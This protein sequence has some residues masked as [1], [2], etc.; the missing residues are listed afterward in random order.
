MKQKKERG[1]LFFT[2]SP[3]GMPFSWNFKDHLFVFKLSSEMKYLKLSESSKITSKEDLDKMKN[4]FYRNSSLKNEVLDLFTHSING[5]SHEIKSFN[6]SGADSDQ[7]DFLNFCLETR[8]NEKNILGEE[9]FQNIKNSEKTFEEVQTKFEKTKKNKIEPAL[10]TV[11]KKH[12][13]KEKEISGN[14]LFDFDKIEQVFGLDYPMKF[15]DQ[16]KKM[17]VSIVEENKELKRKDSLKEHTQSLWFIQIYDF[18]HYNDC[19][20]NFFYFSSLLKKS[21]SFSLKSSSNLDKIREMPFLNHKKLF[22]SFS[23]NLLHLLFTEFNYIDKCYFWTNDLVALIFVRNLLSPRVNDFCTLLHFYIFEIFINFIRLVDFFHVKENDYLEL[24]NIYHNSEDNKFYAKSHSEYYSK[25]FVKLNCK[26]FLLKSLKLAQ[27]ESFQEQR[28][29]LKNKQKIHKTMHKNG[30]SRRIY[31]MKEDISYSSILSEK[32]KK[33]LKEDLKKCEEILM[34]Q[35]DV[36]NLVIINFFCSFEPNIQKLFAHINSTP[37]PTTSQS[38]LHISNQKS[39][40]NFKKAETTEIFE[41]SSLNNFS[42]YF[43]IE[44]N[45]KLTSNDFQENTPQTDS[46]NIP[47]NESVLFQNQSHIESKTTHKVSLGMLSN[48]HNSSFFEFQYSE[49]KQEARRGRKY[50]HPNNAFS[51]SYS[52]TLSPFY[53]SR[54][55]VH[56]LGTVYHRIPETEVIECSICDQPVK[57]LLVVCMKCGHGGH[58]N[59]LES[60]FNFA[61]NN[62]SAHSTGNKRLCPKCK[63]CECQFTPIRK[64]LNI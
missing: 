6:T 11:S 22:F 13:Q 5:T 38:P 4:N 50:S 46:G 47:K 36:Q 15:S 40:Q 32:Q 19:F 3:G 64:S 7:K 9:I 53:K 25:D 48:Y 52:K 51:N 55:K 30:V 43:S 33:K 1:D 21:K 31:K 29:I 44:N 62:G 10:K 2:L 23:T 61:K 26:T 27:S 34:Y 35:R 12:K 24:G 45:Q 37:L 63:K 49:N 17:V 56:D 41:K 16:L 42:K 58:Y 18:W 60:Y 39:T 28:K 20:N 59:H 14:F 57:Q 8:N 54:D